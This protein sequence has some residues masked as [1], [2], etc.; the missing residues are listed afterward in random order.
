MAKDVNPQDVIE[1]K[2]AL[3]G[4]AEI[5]S[6]YLKDLTEEGFSR[7]EALRIVIAYQYVTFGS[8]PSND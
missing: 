6:G 3:T 2:H 8:P 5:L 4:V 1:L 7:E